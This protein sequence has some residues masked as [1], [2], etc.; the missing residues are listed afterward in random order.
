MAMTYSTSMVELSAETSARVLDLL[1]DPQRSKRR[2]LPVDWGQQEDAA[3]LETLGLLTESGA[4]TSLGWKVAG[5]VRNPLGRISLNGLGF[6]SAR[7]FELFL[8]SELAV[9]F[10]SA[11]PGTPQEVVEPGSRFFAVTGLERSLMHLTG[12]LNIS[13]R[14]EYQ[15]SATRVRWMNFAAESRAM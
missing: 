5:I 6:S 8:G 9:V 4:F 7:S 12:W 15:L 10:S 1:N 13:P 3:L 2:A 14:P 11:P